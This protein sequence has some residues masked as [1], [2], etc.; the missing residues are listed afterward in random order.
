MFFTYIQ[1]L[2]WF[3]IN[4]KFLIAFINKDITLQKK[5]IEEERQKHLKFI[6]Q[7]FISKHHT[8]HIQHKMS[9]WHKFQSIETKNSEVSYPQCG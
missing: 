7:K 3:Y 8:Q 1:Q 5:K 4:S 6:P 2:I 9:E